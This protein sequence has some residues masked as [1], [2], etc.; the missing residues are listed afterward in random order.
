M[1]RLLSTKLV[2]H[3]IR[4]HRKSSCPSS[5]APEICNALPASY[6]KLMN[7]NI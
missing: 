6:Y 4:T 1:Y 2:L 7:T 3:K 5:K